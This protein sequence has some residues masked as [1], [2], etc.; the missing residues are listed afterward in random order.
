M[1]RNWAL[2]NSVQFEFS[3]FNDLQTISLRILLYETP[4]KWRERVKF[5]EEWHLEAEFITGLKLDQNPQFSIV[6][7]LWLA[8][9]RSSYVDLKRM[10]T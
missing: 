1:K 7:W 10:L 8:A 6:V 4:Q 5:F 9:S 3:C 2:A